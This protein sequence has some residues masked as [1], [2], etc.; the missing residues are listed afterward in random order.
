MMMVMMV[1]KMMMMMMMM[2]MFMMVMFMTMTKVPLRHALGSKWRVFSSMLEHRVHALLKWLHAPD[3]VSLIQSL[4]SLNSLLF[5]ISIKFK[6]FDL[7]FRYYLLFRIDIII[8]MC[9][10]NSHVHV[11]FTSAHD[12]HICMCYS[13]T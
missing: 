5:V 12:L 3:G 13:A 7:Q 11:L 4:M 9:T 10:C 6:G 1:M 2:M 8:H